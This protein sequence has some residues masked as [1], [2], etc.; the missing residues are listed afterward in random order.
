VVPGGAHERRFVVQEVADTYRQDLN[1]FGPIYKQLK[2]GGY[3]AMLFD[4]LERDLGDWHPR[5]IVRTA[6]LAGQQEKSLSP[7][8]TW[9]LELLQT[10]VLTGA[11]PLS[12]DRA[13]SNRYEEEEVIG[14]DGYG[15]KRT[16]KVFRDG[17][18]DQARRISPKLKGESDTGARALSQPTGLQRR[19]RRLLGPSSS[20]VAI[21]AT[22]RMPPALARTFSGDRLARPRNDAMDHRGQR[23]KQTRDNLWRLKR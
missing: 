17:L 19:W 12:P 9:W 15:G 4:L 16:R 22:D 10:G 7:L 13:V 14:T 2:T 5:Q 6:A 21:P 1:W 3:Q 20:R 11:D 23:L 8:D 18:Y